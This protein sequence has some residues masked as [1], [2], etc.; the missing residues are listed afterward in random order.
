MRALA[1]RQ[2]A[3]PAL[4]REL[5]LVKENTEGPARAEADG[6]SVSQHRPSDRIAADRHLDSKQAMK[7]GRQDQQSS[8]SSAVTTDTSSMI[9]NLSPPTFRTCK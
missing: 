5:P 2:V 3:H 4:G 6:Q 1:S 9:H 7:E 8:A